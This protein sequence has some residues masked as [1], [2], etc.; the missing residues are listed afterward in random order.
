MMATQPIDPNPDSPPQE[1]PIQ[2]PDE[3]VPGQGDVDHPDSVPVEEPRIPDEIG[4]GQGD[5]DQPDAV[6][7]EEPGAPG[8][9]PSVSRLSS[10]GRPSGRYAAY[11]DQ[12]PSL[13][14]TVRS[15]IR[16]PS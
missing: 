8:A 2:A 12:R 15:M 13:L 5:T 7:A 1:T 11:A 3:I 16:S 10:R 9:D 14:S 4:P 6:P